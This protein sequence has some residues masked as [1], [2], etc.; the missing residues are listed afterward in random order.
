[1]HIIL[2]GICCLSPLNRLMADSNRLVTKETMGRRGNQA[3]LTSTAFTISHYHGTIDLNF[4]INSIT[5]SHTVS[6][7]NVS[8][9]WLHRTAAVS[10]HPLV[11]HFW[12][13]GNNLTPLVQE[14]PNRKTVREGNEKRDISCLLLFGKATCS[15][16]QNYGR[17]TH[18]YYILS[19]GIQRN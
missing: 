16:Q 17:W 7:S 14:I 1:M 6:P 4:I 15:R 8:V 19:G 2:P 18:Q 10:Y 11:H 13:N 12:P 5:S 3:R 9:S